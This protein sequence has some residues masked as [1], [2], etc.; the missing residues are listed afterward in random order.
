MFTYQQ[1]ASACKNLGINPNIKKDLN[2]ILDGRPADAYET[3]F[4]LAEIG[5]PKQE[6]AQVTKIGKMIYRLTSQQKFPES[7]NC[8]TAKGKRELRD[9]TIIKNF[10][11]TA[12]TSQQFWFEKG[13]AACKANADDF[14]LH[15]N[16]IVYKVDHNI[17]KGLVDLFE[18]TGAPHAPAYIPDRDVRYTSTKK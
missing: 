15:R 9:T 8:I 4:N 12:Q 16:G 5:F 1:L 13:L 2:L 6:L 18:T 10:L 3:P 14:E 17:R 7:F 11:P